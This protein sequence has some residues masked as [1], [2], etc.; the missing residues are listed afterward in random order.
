M[1]KKKEKKKDC[2][3]SKSVVFRNLVLRGSSKAVKWMV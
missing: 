3:S 1:Y 2:D